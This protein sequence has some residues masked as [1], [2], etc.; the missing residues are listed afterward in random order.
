MIQIETLKTAEEIIGGVA[1]PLKLDTCSSNL[2]AFDCKTG[3]IL[4][5]I[6]GSV[7]EDCYARKGNYRF[8]NVQKALSKRTKL[9]GDKNWVNAWVYVIQNKKKIT[10]TKLFRHF[11]SGDI[12]NKEHLKKIIEVARRTPETKHWLPTKESNIIKN[13]KERI[14]SN[15]IIRLSGT[16]VNGKP[17]AYTYTSTVSTDTNKATC[18]AF[19]NEG[20][21]NGCT[22]CWDKSIKNIT[23]LKH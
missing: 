21:C 20:K 17:P 1:N 23:Y 10:K 8:P 4:A 12:Q 18:R 9:I 13:Y 3:S 15:L 11:D 16:M 6:K 7:C 14:P 19:E 5:K 22:M 2:S